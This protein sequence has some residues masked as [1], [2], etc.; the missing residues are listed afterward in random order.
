MKRI[1]KNLTIC[2]WRGDSARIDSSA[3]STSTPHS[4]SETWGETVGIKSCT[5]ARTGGGEG[6][7]ITS[8]RAGVSISSKEIR[9]SLASLVRLSSLLWVG[10]DS[11]GNL[12]SCKWLPSLLSSLSLL[13]VSSF[14]TGCWL[15]S[16]NIIR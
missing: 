1:L 3:E 5:S 13:T 9:E 14:C 6:C 2:N 15:F 7:L 10:V 12:S 8:T 11:G 4:T 16:Q